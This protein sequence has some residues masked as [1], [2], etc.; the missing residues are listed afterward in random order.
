MIEDLRKGISPA[1]SLKRVLITP[2]SR[3]TIILYGYE[4]K[5]DETYYNIAAPQ[6]VIYLYNLY[7]YFYVALTGSYDTCN[8]ENSINIQD[9]LDAL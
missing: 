1:V 8:S 5:C 7:T 6:I 3:S 2:E 9:T 4:I